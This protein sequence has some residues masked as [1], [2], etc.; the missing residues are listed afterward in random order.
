[1]MLA[2]NTPQRVGTGSSMRT[3][4]FARALSQLGDLTIGLFSPVEEFKPGSIDFRS[5]II[6]PST[7]DALHGKSN[8]AGWFDAM[9]VALMPWRDKWSGLLRYIVAMEAETAEETSIPR[10]ALASLFRVEFAA[11]N[12]FFDPMPLMAFWQWKAF[13]EIRPS[14]IQELRRNKYDVLWFEHGFNVPLLEELKADVDSSVVIV[15]NAHNMEFHLAEQF[16]SQAVDSLDLSA[17]QRQAHLVKRTEV[18]SFRTSDLVVVCS[19]D[20]RRIALAEAPD[21][22]VFTA[23]NGVDTNYFRPLR[24]LP[25]D[26]LPTVLFTGLFTYP[27][28]LDAAKYFLTEILPLIRQVVADCRVVF[29][30]R[31]AG[32]ALEQYIAGLDGIEC[33]T[34]PVDMRPEFER[35]WA[36]VAPLRMGGGTRLKILEAMAMECAVVSTSI[37]A[38][39]MPYVHGTHFLSADSPATF[40][41]EVIRLLRDEELRSALAQNAA[42]LVRQEYDWTKVTEKA[43][44]RLSQIIDMKLAR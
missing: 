33:V 2:S 44:R 38:E 39:G 3:Y 21:A 32:P 25:K 42:I 30:G 8:A 37:G 7:V 26:E 34:D 19:D 24:S 23:E 12:R 4:Y 5:R 43:T 9:T 13:S 27:P 20:D 36:F 31:R 1:M 28:N 29:A 6:Q 17:W 15:C 11:A 22:N 14:L 10:R 16:A 41:R 40:A 18:R 35:A